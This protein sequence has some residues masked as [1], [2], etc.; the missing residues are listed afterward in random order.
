MRMLALVE[1]GVMALFATVVAK[2][3]PPGSN[4]QGNPLPPTAAAP[5][6]PKPTVC[7]LPSNSPSLRCDKI[8]LLHSREALGGFEIRVDGKPM[9]IG[10]NRPVIGYVLGGELRWLDLA[11]A[12]QRKMSSRKERGSL[13]VEFQ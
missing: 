13:L 8:E 4:R 6:W 12:A 7:Q 3:E 10:Q 9:A 2:G 11:E 5:A 1:L